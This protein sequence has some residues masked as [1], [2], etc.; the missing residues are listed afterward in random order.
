MKVATCVGAVIARAGG[1]GIRQAIDIANIH[2]VAV[3]IAP[4]LRA[5]KQI[6]ETFTATT[7]GGNFATQ[8][9]GRR[10]NIRRAHVEQSRPGTVAGVFYPAFKRYTAG[11]AVIRAVAGNKA[12]GQIDEWGGTRG[13]AR[14]NNATVRERRR[15]THHC[16]RGPG[17]NRTDCRIGN[18]RPIRCSSI[19]GIKGISIRRTE[20]QRRTQINKVV[21]L[22]I[23]V[24]QHLGTCQCLRVNAH[25][26]HRHGST[27]RRLHGRIIG[28]LGTDNHG[29][30]RIGIQ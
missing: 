3:G 17:G 26:R 13:A 1:I 27:K 22:E 23:V 10:I 24:V 11:T 8:N 18:D 25:P 2:H 12:V 29:W 21:L 9:S 30:N 20:W 19:R 5:Q 28:H 4:V 14:Q 7:H 16:V 6:V 15:T